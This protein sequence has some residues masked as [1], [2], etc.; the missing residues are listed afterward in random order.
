[1]GL[2]TCSPCRWFLRSAWDLRVCRNPNVQYMIRLGDCKFRT[3]CLGIDVRTCVYRTTAPGLNQYNIDNN[4]TICFVTH[5]PQSKF[6]L[7]TL[8]LE[9]YA[10]STANIDFTQSTGQGRPTTRGLAIQTA[11]DISD[12]CGATTTSRPELSLSLELSAHETL[13]APAHPSTPTQHFFA[14]QKSREKKT[15]QMAA[16]KVIIVTGA[17]RGM[18]FAL[19]QAPIAKTTAVNR[20]HTHKTAQTRERGKADEKYA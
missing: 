8:H 1:M 5:T 11:Q 12:V 15:K 9:H 18:T 10:S 13:T 17:S 7:F 2:G 3:V 19:P 16:S 20:S 14:T 4:H 6:V